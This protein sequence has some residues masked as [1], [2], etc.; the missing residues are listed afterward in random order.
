[1]RKN[2]GSPDINGKIVDM[3]HKDENGWFVVRKATL[4]EILDR[5]DEC[6][7]MIKLNMTFYEQDNDFDYLEYAAFW[8]SQLTMCID[9]INAGTYAEV[10]NYAV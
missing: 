8:G 6:Q 5:A 7:K 4:A 2:Y 1:M 3:D 9:C 10:D